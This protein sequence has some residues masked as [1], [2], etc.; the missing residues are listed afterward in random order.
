MR[1]SEK[2]CLL[3]C[4]I[5]SRSKEH[6]QSRLVRIR[7]RSPGPSLG[8]DKT[9]KTVLYNPA[10]RGEVRREKRVLLVEAKERLIFACLFAG[11]LL[12]HSKYKGLRCTAKIAS[13]IALYLVCAVRPRVINITN[14]PFR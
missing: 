6:V 4:T 1:S 12:E 13:T 2:V 11:A 3:H 9:A 5:C 8:R 10:K 7:F 14:N